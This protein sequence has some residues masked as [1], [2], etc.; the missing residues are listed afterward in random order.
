MHTLSTGIHQDKSSELR[1]LWHLHNFHV[2]F[3]RL[4]RLS[5]PLSISLRSTYSWQA[6]N[7]F[8]GFDAGMFH[9]DLHVVLNNIMPELQCGSR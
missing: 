1:R 9:V 8:S 3:Q 4:L 2:Y 6:L 7:E 5:F